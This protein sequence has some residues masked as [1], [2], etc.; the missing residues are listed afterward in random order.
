MGRLRTFVPNILSSESRTKASTST[1]KSACLSAQRQGV[2]VDDPQ[3]TA[4]SVEICGEDDHVCT[5]FFGRRRRDQSFTIGL[6]GDSADGLRER[7]PPPLL[8]CSPRLGQ[9]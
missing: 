2:F 3:P 9:Q 1:C 5:A 8:K 4:R 7:F 6:V